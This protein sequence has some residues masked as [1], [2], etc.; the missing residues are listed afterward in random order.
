MKNKE[1]ETSLKRWRVAE[2]GRGVGTLVTTIAA[3]DRDI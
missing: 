1:I 2:S 3:Y